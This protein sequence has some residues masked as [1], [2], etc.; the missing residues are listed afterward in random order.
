MYFFS[1][2]LILCRLF[3][4]LLQFQLDLF[5]VSLRFTIL[6]IFLVTANIS[7]LQIKIEICLLISPFNVLN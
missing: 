4:L 7:S 5:A 2:L 6:K 3:D 1:F